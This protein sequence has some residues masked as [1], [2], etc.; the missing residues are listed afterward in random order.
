M[1]TE[2][3]PGFQNGVSTHRSQMPVAIHV[4]GALPIELGFNLISPMDRHKLVLGSQRIRISK[5]LGVQ[6]TVGLDLILLIS[7]QLL[8]SVSN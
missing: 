7:V 1:K 5:Q 6:R 2:L 3:R 8:V 4:I